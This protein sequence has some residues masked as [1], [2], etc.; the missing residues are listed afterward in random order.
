[1]GRPRKSVKEL[2]A[3]GTLKTN[4][5]RKRD[6][7]PVPTGPIGEPPEL[8]PKEQHYVWRELIEEVPP[9]VLT[10]ADRHHFRLTCGLCWMYDTMG[11]VE[12]SSSKIKDMERA[13]GKYGLTPVDR[14]RINI[15]PEK[16]KN[17][18]EGIGGSVKPQA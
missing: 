8:M 3:S 13:L 7:E 6:P 16:K 12:M 18:F 10:N 9:G 5:N 11:V 14:N 17:P 15:A 2:E 4:P 1:M